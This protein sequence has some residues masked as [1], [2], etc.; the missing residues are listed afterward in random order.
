G[1]VYV[2]TR[3]GVIWSQQAYVKASVV[4]AYDQ[5]GT[6]VALSADGA[7]LAVGASRE[8][9]PLTNAG[10]VSVFT[11]SGMTWSQQARG[12]RSQ[13]K[14]AFGNS[15]ALSADGAWLAVGA[16]RED[17][18]GVSAGAVYVFMQSGTAWNEHAYLKA[19]NAGAG[20]NFGESVALSADGTILVA[21]APG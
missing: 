13:A 16:S 18:E 6:S 20:D 14:G 4:N 19:S 17:S 3:S 10:A 15:V 8:E 9:T 21:G 2:F 7:T 11:R 5:F 1:A 12:T